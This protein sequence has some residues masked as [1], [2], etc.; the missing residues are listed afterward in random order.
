M[1]SPHHLLNTSWTSH[2]LSP[3][4]Y[5]I[6]K[7]AESYSL[8]TNRTA[9]D[10]YAARLRGYLTNS[11]AVAGAPTLQHDPATSATLG[12]LQSCTWEAISSLSFLDANMISQYGGEGAFEQNEEEPAGLLITLTYENA[13]YKAALLSAGSVSRNQSQN[14]EQLQKQRKRKRGRPSLKSS[15]TTVS[16][17]THLPLLLTRLPK[18][19]RESFFSFL[20]SNFDTYVSALRISSQGLCGILESYLSGLTPAGAVNADVE[21]IM[22]E[23]HITLSFAPPIAPS[24]KALIVC[25]P[26]E[27]SGGFIRVP[28]ST[29][30]G[31]AGNSVLSG[32]SA[33]LSKHLALDLRLPLLEGEAVTTAGSLLTGGHVRLTRIACAGFV[34]TS[35]GRLKI[36]AKAEDRAGGGEGDERKR[37]ELRSGEALLRAVLKR[38]GNGMGGGF[39]SHA[40]EQD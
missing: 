15:I 18:P 13:T 11:L 21:E 29:Y 12:A 4:H 14:Q 35:E 1:A 16:A 6:N 10:T 9:L 28:G 5:E 7:N 40:E 39:D 31:K 33:Y 37:G 27:T 17:S 25:I 20:G 36:V 24:L 26:S 2:R 23:L 8:L 32:L 19:L 30:A 22:R 34:V 38:A 3:L